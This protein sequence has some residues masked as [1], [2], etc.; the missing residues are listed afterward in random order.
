MMKQN[1][2]ALIVAPL[3]SSAELDFVQAW[4]AKASSVF[5]QKSKIIGFFPEVEV[6]EPRC[7]DVSGMQGLPEVAKYLGS[8]HFVLQISDPGPTHRG[9]I[10]E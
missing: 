8:T 2:H 1:S 3:L 9:A 10:D 5:H 7:V 6:N 4:I